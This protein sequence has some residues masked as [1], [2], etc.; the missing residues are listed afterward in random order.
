MY[1]ITFNRGHGIIE[2]STQS[3][4]MTTKRFMFMFAVSVMKN[5]S[6]IVIHDKFWKLI[7][8]MVKIYV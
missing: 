2:R 5:K 3:K 4:E 7:Y 6:N 8:S 1:S